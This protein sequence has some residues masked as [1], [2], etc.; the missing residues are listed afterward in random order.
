MWTE[1]LWKLMITAIV[2]ILIFLIM[3]SLHEFGHFIFGKLLKFTVLEYAIGFGPA[4]FKKQKGDTLYSV[5]IIPFGGY[6]R[7]AGEDENDRAE[8]GNFND[9][10]CWKRVIVLA[11]GAIFNVLLGFIIFCILVGAGKSYYTNTIE[12]IVPDSYLS[13]TVVEPGD[14][15]IRLN[16]KKIGMYQDI[17]LYTSDLNDNSEINMTV[18]RDGKKINV[19]I[20]PTRQDVKVTYLEDHV[21][22]EETVNGVY[23]SEEIPY[24]DAT[25]KNSENIG[26]V[27]EETRYL[28]GFMPKEE[29]INAFNLLPQSFRM[30][31]FVVKL[32]YTS[33]WD[34]V[35]GHGSPDDVSGPV[36]VVKEVNTAVNS[37]SDSWLYVLNLVAL[38]TINLG[39]FNLLPLPALDGGRLLFV[40]IEWFRGKPVSRDKEGIIHAIGFMLLIALMLFISFKDIMKLITG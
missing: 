11:A 32:L 33:L 27:M 20:K 3:I 14:K 21:L 8:D 15:I 17:S 25:P 34:L 22:Y 23:S 5:R 30:T 6:C 4:I 26:K 31:K 18:L 40:I 13:E 7:F 38:L 16:D 1:R 10:P 35:T 29:K 36:G 24:S 28:I 9:Q 12:Q 19:D 39:V 37:G 2:T